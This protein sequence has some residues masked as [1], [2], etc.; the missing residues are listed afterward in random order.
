MNATPSKDHVTKEESTTDEL[1][2]RTYGAGGTRTVNVK[3]PYNDYRT[4]KGIK[5]YE[6]VRNLKLQRDKHG[7]FVQF[8][9]FNWDIVEVSALVLNREGSAPYRCLMVDKIQARD[10]VPAAAR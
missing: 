9:G 8:N 2:Q 3:F 10:T 4:S 6:P 1:W 7:L 5:T